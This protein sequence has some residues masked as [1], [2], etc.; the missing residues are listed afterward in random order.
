MMCVSLLVMS[1]VVATGTAMQQGKNAEAFGEYQNAQAEANAQAKEGEGRVLATKARRAGRIAR[2]EIA[3]QAGASGLD[4]NS[5]AF[6]D[7]EALATA[8]YE[9]DA[10]AAI[11]TGQNEGASLRAG[12]SYAAAQGSAEKRSALA[13]GASSALKGWSGYQARSAQASQSQQRRELA[14]NQSRG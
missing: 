12:G 10:L 4:I 5:Q 7:A 2:S 1:A 13:Q 8:S 6:Q 14:I 3:T 11:Y 9:T